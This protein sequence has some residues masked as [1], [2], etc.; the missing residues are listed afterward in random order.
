MSWFVKDIPK[1]DVGSYIVEE[2]NEDGADAYG[3]LVEIRFVSS[4]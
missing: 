2:A 1:E 4:L 3:A